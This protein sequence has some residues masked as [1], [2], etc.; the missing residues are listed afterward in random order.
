MERKGKEEEE[1]TERA[2]VIFHN[3]MTSPRLEENR[4]IHDVSLSMRY[5]RM[6]IW[7][8]ALII[9]VLAERPTIDLKGGG[10]GDGKVG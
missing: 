3:S 7:K 2:L 5:S 1:E 10:E 4:I 8:K 9:S 6:I